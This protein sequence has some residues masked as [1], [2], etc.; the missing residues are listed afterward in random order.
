ML[1]EAMALCLQKD[2]ALNPFKKGKEVKEK[3]ALSESSPLQVA[4][5]AH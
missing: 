1:S 3:V 5:M 2:K 4:P